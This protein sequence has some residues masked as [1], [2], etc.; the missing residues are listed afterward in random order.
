MASK[1]QISNLS[2]RF[3]A[4]EPNCLGPLSSQEYIHCLHFGIWVLKSFAGAGFNSST[5]Q[6]LDYIQSEP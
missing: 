5:A 3:A 1:Y 4:A 6:Q 2:W